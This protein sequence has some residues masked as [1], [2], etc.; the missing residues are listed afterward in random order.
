MHGFSAVN[1]RLSLGYDNAFYALILFSKTLSLV[2]GS[3]VAPWRWVN[4][5][6]LSVLLVWIMVWQRLT[7]LAEG[8][9]GAGWTFFISSLHLSYL[10]FPVS[11]GYGLI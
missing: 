6:C 11:L 3:Q 7:M 5:K 8:A 10:F 4:F 2:W 1:A 9:G